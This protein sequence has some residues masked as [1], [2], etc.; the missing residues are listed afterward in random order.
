MRRW[1]YGLIAPAL[2][3]GVCIADADEAQGDLKKSILLEALPQLTAARGGSV[4]ITSTAAEGF[5]GSVDAKLVGGEPKADLFTKL[6][7]LDIGS[8]FQLDFF[9]ETFE[10]DMPR[11]LRNDSTLKREMFDASLASA[12]FRGRIEFNRALIVEKFQPKACLKGLKRKEAGLMLLQGVSPRNIVSELPVAE[13][14]LERAQK[15]KE[16]AVAAVAAVVLPR[17][18]DPGY[19]K[20]QENKTTLD[21][22]VRLAER[23]VD[24]R[25][26]EVQRLND[27]VSNL[28][29]CRPEEWLGERTM[30]INIGAR[31]LRRSPAS[32]GSEGGGSL[33]YAIELMGQYILEMKGYGLTV[34]AGLSAIGF[35]AAT[36]KEA[37]S[38][39]EYPRFNQARV[40]V[41]FEFRGPS[42]TLDKG[43]IPRA[44][45]YAV[46]G[47]AWWHD[48]YTFGTIEPRVQ[49]SELEVGI[50]AGG[51]FQK[52]FHGLIALR[53][54]QPYGTDRSNVYILS[55]MPS[56]TGSEGRR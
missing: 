18:D 38:V 19:A 29:Y 8:R 24:R 27:E 37:L 36:D 45:I 54:V 40:S 21:V 52:N 55:L 3:I 33:G 50:Y 4:G 23:E 53:V 35:G 5:Q 32:K 43:T 44:G 28:I 41:S 56:V 10:Q 20:A 22:D 51:R 25:T 39:T 48:K 31:V 42:F 47:H 49:S 11:F 15:A 14:A 9:G 13:L 1:C 30:A 12:G 7:G 17:T 6:G 26:K 46:G 34:S 16:T 2:C